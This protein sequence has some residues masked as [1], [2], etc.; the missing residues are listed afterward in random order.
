M[1][2]IIIGEAGR[3]CELFLNRTLTFYYLSHSSIDDEDDIGP[4]PAPPCLPTD[5]HSMAS[6]RPS[7]LPF[8]TP[9]HI[10]YRPLFL[11]RH[12]I[13]PEKNNHIRRRRHRSLTKD[14]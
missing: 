14:M 5:P 13:H 3:E 8:D 10:H 2:V 6:V 9:N 7:V 4:W 11:L 1:L 12:Q